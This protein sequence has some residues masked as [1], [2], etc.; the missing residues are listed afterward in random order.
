MPRITLSIKF[1]VE[2]SL[3]ANESISKIDRYAPRSFYLFIL[4]Y[5]FPHSKSLLLSTPMAAHTAR[6]PR[7][8]ISIF[9]VFT[10]L[11]FP[12]FSYFFSKAETEE[13]KMSW[14]DIECGGVADTCKI[15]RCRM[16]AT[17]SR[18]KVGK[19]KALDKSSVCVVRFAHNPE[20]V[21]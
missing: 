13:K 20:H 10:K 8:A 16:H 17:H 21:L 3:E 12:K 11:I 9:T 7:V 6:Q 15:Y 19:I 4:R 1:V 5:T 14:N 2:K 18:S